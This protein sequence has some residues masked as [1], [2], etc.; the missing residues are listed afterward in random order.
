[1]D[2]INRKSKYGI[3]T[4]SELAQA[5]DTEHRLL[6]KHAPVPMPQPP[7]ERQKFI[8]FLRAQAEQRVGNFIRRIP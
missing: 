8:R 6:V 4:D 2:F 1:M 7:Q 5:I 3:L